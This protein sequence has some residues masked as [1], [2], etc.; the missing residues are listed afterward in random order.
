MA[1][2]EKTEGADGCM[3]IKSGADAIFAD[4]FAYA[5]DGNSV[6]QELDVEDGCPAGVSI[7]KFAHVSQS[8]RGEF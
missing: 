7:F 5:V 8:R 6:D 4:I 1:E 2:L 3:A